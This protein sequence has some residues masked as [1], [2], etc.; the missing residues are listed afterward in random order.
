[1][2]WVCGVFVNKPNASF[3]S[4][5]GFITA[6]VVAIV[7]SGNFENSEDSNRAWDVNSDMHT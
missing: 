7:A 6:V 1:V 2:W 5:L 4:I 3:F